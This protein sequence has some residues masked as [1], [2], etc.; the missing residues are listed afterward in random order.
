M[1][2]MK[3]RSV[4]LSS[5]YSAK[6]HPVRYGCLRASQ[7]GQ[8]CDEAQWDVIEADMDEGVRIAGGDEKRGE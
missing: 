7:A 2:S 5:R 3:N 4:P 6:C 1:S 8:E